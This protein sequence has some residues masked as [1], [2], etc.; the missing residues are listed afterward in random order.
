MKLPFESQSDLSVLFELLHV[1]GSLLVH[2]IVFWWLL[3][4]R[5]GQESFYANPTDLYAG[6]R[7]G[8]GG[9]IVPQTCFGQ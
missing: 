6:L 5:Q 2:S 8:L 7:T 3:L 9:T 4:P 1:I